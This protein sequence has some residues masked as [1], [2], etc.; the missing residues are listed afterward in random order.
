[1]NP[2]IMNE[3]MQVKRDLRSPEHRNWYL[4]ALGLKHPDAL[5]AFKADLP[6]RRYYEEQLREYEL[7]QKHGGK[8]R[9]EKCNVFAVQERVIATLG[10]GL[11]GSEYS[12]LYKCDNCGHE[13]L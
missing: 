3:L 4:G 7:E 5:T 8:K 2:I 1:M 13:E 12:V 9:C 6:S 11:P 10:G